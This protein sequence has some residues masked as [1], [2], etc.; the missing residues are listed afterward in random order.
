MPCLALPGWAV[1]LP[2]DSA[3]FRA[4]VACWG[5]AGCHARGGGAQ[6]GIGIHGR[7]ALVRWQGQ[8]HEGPAPALWGVGDVGTK[9]FVVVLVSSRRTRHL[10][11]YG[12]EWR[13]YGSTGSSGM[14]M[15]VG[16]GGCDG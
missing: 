7:W 15:E 3:S 9:V 8:A 4:A 14:G 13:R 16:D 11:G 2:V 6:V 1:K 5:I 10:L 12:A